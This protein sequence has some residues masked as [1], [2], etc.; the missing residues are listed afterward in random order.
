MADPSPVIGCPPPF[1]WDAAA[2]DPL[3]GPIDTE[4][5]VRRDAKAC[6]RDFLL[7]PTIRR[8]ARVVNPTRH[9]RAACEV[10]HQVLGHCEAHRTEVADELG[11]KYPR[12]ARLLASVSAALEI[13]GVVPAAA[14]FPRELG[15]PLAD[16]L[17]RFAVGLR[18][19]GGS[20]GTIMLG[21]DR[22][23]GE[24]LSDIP[25]RTVIKILTAKSGPD[26]WRR[27][28]EIA[29]RVGGRCG[30]R[31]IDAGP[32]ASWGGYI[33]MERIE[34]MSLNALAAAEVRVPPE[35][36]ATELAH[37]ASTLASLHQDGHEH[38][39]VAPANVML[40]R[41]GQFRLLDYSGVRGGS[42][43]RDVRALG[44]LGLWVT[45]GYLP[46]PG[47]TVPA[48]WSF[49]DAAV[50]RVSTAAVNEELSASE[51]AEQ[52]MRTV[53]RARM[54]RNALVTAAVAGV[55]GALLYLAPAEQQGNTGSTDGAQGKSNAVQ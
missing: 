30:I 53:R 26:E 7:V 38:G 16:G 29:S 10:V 51:F 20:H 3:G 44:A 5:C 12:W 36:A 9:E 27:E 50:V 41:R 25:A 33:A 31:V 18:L 28:S 55:L 47:T 48:Q 45:I 23:A 14:P 6:L 40:D 37:L 4:V 17:P 49:M 32:L 19:A 15:P 42:G 46:P 39:D 24:A 2:D 43:N 1:R 13:V 52:M 11:A 54:I 35:Q 8:Y 34:G 21:A 22:L